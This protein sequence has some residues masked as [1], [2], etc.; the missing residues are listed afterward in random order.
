MLGDERP[1]GIISSPHEVPTNTMRHNRSL[2]FAIDL[3]IV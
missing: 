1:H 2:L 3:A